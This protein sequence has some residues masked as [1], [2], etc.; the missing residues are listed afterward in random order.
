MHEDHRRFWTGIHG[1]L[2]SEDRDGARGQKQSQSDCNDSRHRL[3]DRVRLHVMKYPSE[4]V[5]RTNQ[6]GGTPT[7]RSILQCEN[8]LVARFASASQFS[9]VISQPVLN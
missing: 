7:E 9:N 6:T 8:M 2:A 4:S 5:S 1:A 3:S